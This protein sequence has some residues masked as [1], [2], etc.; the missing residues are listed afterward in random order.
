MAASE[1]AAREVLARGGIVAYPT[2]A[3]YGLGCD[4]A[5]AA[6]V[7]RL[8]TLKGRDVRKGLIL[9]AA[10]IQGLSPWIAEP[11]PEVRARLDRT[12]P[13]PVTW[14][15][16]A[17]SDCPVQVRGDHDTVAARV[18]AH[19]AAADLCRAWGGALVSTSANRSGAAPARDASRVRRLFGDEIDLVI[20]GPVGGLD[21][22]TPIRDARTGAT[23][24]E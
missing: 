20:D 12:W 10:D 23:I 4:P 6:A 22:P 17:S 3:V 9:I 24:R 8:L 11:T 1:P 21:R 18:T 5:N 16:P 15:L 14:L 13:G 19:P 2:E 7:E